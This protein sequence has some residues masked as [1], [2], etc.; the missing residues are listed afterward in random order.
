M[1][2]RRS[3]QKS[4]AKLEGA[5]PRAVDGEERNRPSVGEEMKESDK[6]RKMLSGRNS[7]NALLLRRI[8][9]RRYSVEH[10]ALF[11]LIT[12]RFSES[13]HSPT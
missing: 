12:Y 5:P 8:W 1:G 3:A 6:S 4:A 13:S 9:V 10:Y 7:R 11:C 2:H